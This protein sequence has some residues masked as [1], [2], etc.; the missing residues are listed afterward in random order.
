MNSRSLII[1]SALF[2]FISGFSQADSR[3][4]ILINKY[5]TKGESIYLQYP[6]SA[7]FYW[8]EAQKLGEKNIESGTL[9]P[10]LLK[11]FKKKLASNLNGLAYIFRNQGNMAKSLENYL[12]AL[13]ISEEAGDNTGTAEILNNIGVLYDYQNDTDNALEYY[14]RSLKLLETTGDKIGM[15]FILNN[16]AYVYNVKQQTDK[17]IEF[18]QKSLAIRIE[19]NDKRGMGESYNNLGS[20]YKD[21]QDFE[22]AFIYLN[23]GL[24]L[25]EEVQDKRG[26]ANSYKNM[27]DLYLKQNKF[28]PALEFGLK[29]IALSKEMGYPE[30]VMNAADKLSKVY[31]GMGDYHKALDNYELYI[32]MR[33]SISNEKTRKEAIKTKFKYEY[34]KKAEADSI[35]VAEQRKTF[36]LRI[37]K[38]KTQKIALYVIILL[39]IIFSLFI[40]NR[41]RITKKQK[42]LIEIKEK[43][44]FEQKLIIETKHNEITASINYAKRIQHSLLPQNKYIDKTLERMQN[45]NRIA[46]GRPFKY[47]NLYLHS[48]YEKAHPYPTT[49]LFI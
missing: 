2:T 27:C 47:S 20:L 29:S 32:T 45:K 48:T 39:T 17:A 4:T 35:K 15:G 40:Y 34:E 3:D 28:K 7:I 16:I 30:M 46:S 21:K 41:F 31:K 38:E 5:S 22:N 37:E 24:Q 43:E 23:K 11:I 6:D 25:R 12:K 49:N 14:G 42:Q 10:Q 33:D 36:D 8:G 18:Y 9:T 26:M 44:T 19:L 1:L 13:K